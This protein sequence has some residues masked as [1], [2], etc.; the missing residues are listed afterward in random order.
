MSKRVRTNYPG[1]FYRETDR[2]GGKGLE[3]VYYVVFKKDGKV[4]EEK[5]GRQYADDMTPA[6]AALIRAELIEGRRSTRQEVKAQ[7]E[8][9][10]EAEQNRWTIERLWI[11]YSAGRSR[12]KSHRTDESRY[13]LYLS[14]AFGNKEPREIVALDAERLKRNLSKKKSPQTVKHVLTLLK[15]IVNFGVQN[16]LCS[17]FNFKVKVPTVHNI[18]TEFL[19]PDELKRLLEEIEKDDHPQAGAVMK[20]ALFSGLRKGEILKLQWRDIDFDHGFIYI[21]DPK[22][23]PSQNIPLNDATRDL[24]TN[25]P[26][27]P[28]SPYIF[29]GKYG[30]MR[31]DIT[32]PVNRIKEKA[33]LPKSFRALHGLRHTY[34]SLLASS[35]EVDMVVLQDLMTHKD[36]RMTKRYIHLRDEARK[37]GSNIISEIINKAIAEQGRDDNKVVPLKK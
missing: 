17:P 2:I 8:A 24:L 36:F 29:P 12:S 13:N 20:L 11:E 22:G 1:V 37:R 18:K 16:G 9:E 6:R 32:K 28:G 21:R 14:K 3:K 27:T 33:G 4:L 10:R 35:G 19:S 5:V 34:A 23:G 25:F 31:T 30:G 7:R 15:R 26:A